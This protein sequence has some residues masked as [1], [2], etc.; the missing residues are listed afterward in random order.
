MLTAFLPGNGSELITIRAHE[1]EWSDLATGVS[2]KSLFDDGQTHSSIVRIAAHTHWIA[3]QQLLAQDEECLLLEGDVFFG[4]TLLR[5]GDWQLAPLGSE[6]LPVST[7]KGAL[8]FMRSARDSAAATQ[9]I[10]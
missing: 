2:S 4:D 5:A 9:N 8:I 10:P 1:G 7:D 6:S 3:Q